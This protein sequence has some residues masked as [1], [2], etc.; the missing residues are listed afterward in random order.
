MLSL[1]ITIGLK[2]S[3][4]PLCIDRQCQLC[5]K[6]TISFPCICFSVCY[7]DET[8]IKQY[9]NSA[10]L[11]CVQYSCKNYRMGKH[12]SKYAMAVGCDRLRCIG[13]ICI[14]YKQFFH[15]NIILK[16]LLWIRN[17]FFSFYQTYRNMFRTT[18]LLNLN[19]GR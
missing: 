5:W 16:Y 3:D 7:H 8:K 19:N 6:V 1:F 4:V 9:S 15:A 14:L 13:P 10:V 18:K 11:A 12:Q 2:S 17:C